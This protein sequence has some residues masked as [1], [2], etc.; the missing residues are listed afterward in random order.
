M[1]AGNSLQN[2]CKK[3][4]KRPQVRRGPRRGMSLVVVVGTPPPAGH[5]I[6]RV[7]FDPFC[8]FFWQPFPAP[9]YRRFL[10]VSLMSAHDS[11]LSAFPPFLRIPASGYRRFLL[12]F[13]VFSYY[14]LQPIPLRSTPAPE[15]SAYPTKHTG[16]EP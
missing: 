9:I 12:V 6:G 2:K 13:D 5:H 16:D 7:V 8:T 11:L 10:N 15:G 3:G 14:H 1:G 4:Q